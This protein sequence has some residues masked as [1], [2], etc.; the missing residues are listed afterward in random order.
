MTREDICNFHLKKK[1]KKANLVEL[2]ITLKNRTEDKMV[3]KNG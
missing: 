3:I 2:K 1:A